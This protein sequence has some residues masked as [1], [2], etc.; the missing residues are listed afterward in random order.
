M[1]CTLRT[2]RDKTETGSMRSSLWVPAELVFLI[3]CIVSHAEKLW[4]G[5]ESDW[6]LFPNQNREHL[7]K[8]DPTEMMREALGPRF[9]GVRNYDGR[10]RFRTDAYRSSHNSKFEADTSASSNKEYENRYCSN[11]PERTAAVSVTADKAMWDRTKEGDGG[12][13]VK[14]PAEQN[15]Q[16]AEKDRADAKEKLANYKKCLEAKEQRNSQKFILTNEKKALLELIEYGM[17]KGEDEPNGPFSR[18]R[19]LKIRMPTSVHY[20]S[21]DWYRLLLGVKGQ[22]GENA[23]QAVLASYHGDISRPWS[24]SGRK[25]LALQKEKPCYYLRNGPLTLVNLLTGTYCHRVLLSTT[26]A[27]HRSMK[28]P[29]PVIFGIKDFDSQQMFANTVPVTVATK[30]AT[31]DMEFVRLANPKYA[32]YANA[33]FNFLI[34]SNPFQDFMKSLYLLPEPKGPQGIFCPPLIEAIKTVLVQKEGNGVSCLIFCGNILFLI[35]SFL[36][37]LETLNK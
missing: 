16:L 1:G 3:Q 27:L 9:A 33:G 19:F 15:R 24:K 12:F 32:C 2:Q 28:A 37:R 7:E 23:R 31:A 13:I 21:S 34:T 29:P 25:S 36:L 30:N 14:E 17:K 5:A 8:I 20:Y 26:I 18:L 4:G 6:P 22:I 10:R 35:F 11:V